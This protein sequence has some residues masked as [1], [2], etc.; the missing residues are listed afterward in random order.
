[1]STQFLDAGSPTV[2]EFQ[3]FVDTL[4]VSTNGTLGTVVIDLNCDPSVCGV[5]EGKTGKF[6]FVCVFRQI[7]VCVARFQSPTSAATSSSRTSRR[8][9]RP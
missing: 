9:T 5:R 7:S 6:G 4:G 1:M 3:A 8:A 2:A